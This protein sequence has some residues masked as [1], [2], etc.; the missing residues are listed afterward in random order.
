[1]IVLLS[2]PIAAGKSSVASELEILGGFKR[3]RSSPYLRTLL[4]ESPEPSREQLQELGDHLDQAT[5]Y[6]WVVDEAARQISEQA[7][8]QNWVFDSVRKQRQV[9]HFR[10]TFPTTILHVHLHAPDDVLVSRYTARGSQNGELA[11]YADAT[12]HPNEQSSRGLFSIAD[13]VLDASSES[14]RKCA[15][16]VLSLIQRQQQ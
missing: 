14:P 11:P 2:G 13:V 8:S 5:D 6:R 15:Q 3:A 10:S 1:M 12:N 9:E 16:Q 4:P 7:S